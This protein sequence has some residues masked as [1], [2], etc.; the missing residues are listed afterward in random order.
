ML[1]GNSFIGVGCV[2]ERDKSHSVC[3]WCECSYIRYS[4]SE[5][6]AFHPQFLLRCKNANVYQFE[7]HQRLRSLGLKVA[8]KR[9]TFAAEDQ[10]LLTRN[11][12]RNLLHN[13]TNPNM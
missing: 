3:Y 10:R 2:N 11:Y 7:T 13:N 9:F 8:T 5:S 1:D 4:V 12:Q 6:I